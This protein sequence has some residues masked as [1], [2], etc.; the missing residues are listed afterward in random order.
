METGV[1]VID[2]L[3]SLD[4]PERM[5]P[6][7]STTS[8]LMFTSGDTTRHR[9]RDVFFSMVQ[10]APVHD[11]IKCRHEDVSISNYSIFTTSLAGTVKCDCGPQ[12]NEK[13]YIHSYAF[14]H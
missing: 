13:I 8:L 6:G 11:P 10:S 12:S 7:T 9:V 5:Q 1:M 3:R 4:A 14:T 2:E